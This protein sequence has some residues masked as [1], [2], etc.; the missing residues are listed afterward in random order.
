MTKVRWV[1]CALFIAQLP[2]AVLEHGIVG[3][4]A[5]SFAIILVGTL[6]GLIVTARPLIV[7]LSV[8]DAAF[9]LY[10]VAIL[11][12]TWLNGLTAPAKQYALLALAVAA[13]PAGRLFGQQHP[14]RA[15]IW[16]LAVLLL[17][18]GFA[19]MLALLESWS[20]PTVAHPVVLG[21]SEA[22]PAQFLS[23]VAFI[24]FALLVVHVDRLER[25]VL[26]AIC[27][28]CA[29]VF[30][31]AQVRFMFVAL[32]M[33]LALAALRGGYRY[34]WPGL[35]GLTGVVAI[36]MSLRA[37]TSTINLGYL[38]APAGCG[39]QRSS[40]AMRKQ[41]FNEAVSLLPSS[42]P[43]GLGLEGF[44][45]KTCLPGGVEV[46]NSLLQAAI[47]FGWVGGAS[48]AVVLLWG[49]LRAPAGFAFYGLAFEFALAMMHGHLA[50]DSI[51]MFFAGYAVRCSSEV[52]VQ[53]P[54]TP[55]RTAATSPDASVSRT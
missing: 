15:F 11:A 5:P 16:L 50:H 9:A 30:A 40:I 36:G 46:H 23:L 34:A 54:S 28:V 55:I 17:A 33:V 1:L 8:A 27:V 12:S 26:L 47:E 24:V 38:L 3:G 13:Y 19:T 18:G 43:F 41:L 49:L 21:V 51:L 53:V 32:A 39:Y 45:A 10:V 14:S 42:G 29:A 25:G 4:G 2:I 20:D 6:A 52:P 37:A 22:V 48:L 31:A 7:R 44:L 35:V